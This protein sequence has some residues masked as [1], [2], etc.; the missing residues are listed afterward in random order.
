VLAVPTISWA[1]Y[2]LTTWAVLPARLRRRSAGPPPD[3]STC[4]EIFLPFSRV[5]AQDDKPAVFGRQ[6]PRLHDFESH[7]G[8]TEEKLTKSFFSTHFRSPAASSASG[9]GKPVPISPGRGN[10]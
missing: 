10:F 5:L 4:N 9:F 8:M 1:G 2:L 6:S 7:D 3:L